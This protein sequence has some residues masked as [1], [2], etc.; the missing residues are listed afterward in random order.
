GFSRF[1]DAL[2]VALNQA[3]DS[4]AGDGDNVRWFT[5]TLDLQLASVDL[6][7]ACRSV[8]TL[9]VKID[10]DTPRS[11][12]TPTVYGGA[13]SAPSSRV[14]PLRAHGV[15]WEIE[16]TFAKHVGLAEEPREV[17]E[18]PR[19]PGGAPASDPQDS[20]SRVLSTCT[21]QL[22]MPTSSD[23][24]SCDALDAPVREIC[25]SASLRRVE[26]GSN[27]DEPVAGIVWPRSLRELSFGWKF[28][29]SVREMAWPPSLREVSF[30]WRFN[31]SIADMRWPDSLRTIALG[32]EFNQ[33]I[34]AAQWPISLKHVLFGQHFNQSISGVQWPGS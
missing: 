1:L 33:P 6:C 11:L 19:P 7:R 27:Y 10:H 9:L 12:W 25:W 21:R 13:N 31:Q 3:Y 5:S 34:V 14:P 17:C 24:P 26:L 23:S 30:G 22:V 15:K 32:G 4:R 29:H 28:N 16:A 2:T 18:D 20:R 8:P